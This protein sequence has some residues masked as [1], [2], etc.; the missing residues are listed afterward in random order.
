MAI[1]TTNRLR[2]LISSEYSELKFHQL[3]ILLEKQEQ[4]HLKKEFFE[5]F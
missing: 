5:F 2:K 1:A 4:N 3:T